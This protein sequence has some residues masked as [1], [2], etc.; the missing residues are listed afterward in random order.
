MQKNIKN[1]IVRI[2]KILSHGGVCSRRDAEELI[3][4]GKVEVNGNISKE[5]L[6]DSKL[7]QSIRV[8]GKEV[9]KKKTALWL[10][11]KPPGYVCSNREQGNQKSIFSLLPKTFPRVVSVGRLDIESEGL[12]LLTNN[13]SLSNF[14]EKPLN[15]IERKYEVK[16]R[17]ELPRDFVQIN[18]GI[19]INGIE[20][21][22][23]LFRLVEKNKI[24]MNLKEGKNREIRRILN[25]F[26]IKVEILKRTRYGPFSLK[27]LKRGDI[28]KLEKKVLKDKLEQI[29]FFNEDNFWSI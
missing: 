17:G 16:I 25:H 12:L 8:N 1:T 10:F 21:K 19:T 11:H 5:F 20:Y 13:P 28:A 15:S 22:S 2:S 29:G 23:I 24:E 26:N 18:K 27:Y 4:I 7:L 14:L 3:R 9:K 6:I